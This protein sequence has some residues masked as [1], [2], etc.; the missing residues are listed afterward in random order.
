MKR[1]RKKKRNRIK[2][3][4]SIF[5]LICALSAVVHIFP[6]F[7]VKA[8]RVD[9][10]MKLTPEEI[11]AMSGLR[12]GDNMI[13]M[14]KK[15]IQQNISQAN[16]VASCKVNRQFPNQ[17]NIIIDENSPMAYFHQK[18]HVVIVYSKGNVKIDQNLSNT[19]GLIQ[20]YG[21]NTDII[22]ENTNI[23]DD[24]NVEKIFEHLKKVEYFSKI[25]S[26][27][28]S[29]LQNIEVMLNGDVRL[30]MGKIADF[31]DN[32]RSSEKILNTVYSKNINIKELN[33]TVSDEPI[34]KKYVENTN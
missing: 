5:F 3:I 15:E 22:Q 21:L 12:I 29:N 30:C 24:K 4:L 19:T 17:V 34:I 9:G 26:V 25:K 7:K 13:G 33:Y 1:K 14:N 16:V 27:D 6:I 32:T 10:N 11:V 2:K 31:P 18:D 23:Y 28:V 8:I 20:I